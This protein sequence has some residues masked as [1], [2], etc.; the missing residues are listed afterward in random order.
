MLISPPLWPPLRVTQKV[1]LWHT[2]QGHCLHFFQHA[3]TVTSV[4]FHPCFEHF[5]LSGCFD[6][7]VRVWNIR[8][9]RVHEWQQAPDMVTAAKFSLDGQMIV[10]GLYM[11]QV[12][13]MLD[14][15]PPRVQCRVCL[16]A[17]VFVCVHVC[18]CGRA[19]GCMCFCTWTCKVCEAVVSVGVFPLACVLWHVSVGL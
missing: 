12:M 11:G 8:D 13:R 1:R 14:R 17:C 9:G 6:K 16:F 15:P 7:K 2:T 10:A 4:D 3:E 19:C 5:F 18:A